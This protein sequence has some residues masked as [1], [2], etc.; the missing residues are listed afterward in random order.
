MPKRPIYRPDVARSTAQGRPQVL[1]ALSV[2]DGEEFFARAVESVLGQ[3]GVDLRLEIYDNGSTDGTLALADGYAAAD[4]RVT[5][6]RNPPGLNY[7]C[8]MNRAIAGCDAEFFCPWACDDVMSPD[9]LAVKAAGLREHPDAGFAWSPSLIVDEHDRIGDFY[10]AVAKLEP[11]SVAPTFFPFLVPIGQVVMSSVLARTEAMRAVGGFDARS[12]LVGDWLCWMKL[13]L[14]FGVVTI[15][16][17]LIHYR[18]HEG[19]GSFAAKRGGYAREEPA[20]LREAMRDPH[21]REEWRPGAAPWM[22]Q[23][24]AHIAHG[25]LENDILRFEQGFAA[26]GLAGQALP[27]LPKDEALVRYWMQL[28]DEAD[29]TRPHY[30]VRVV[31]E[32]TTDEPRVVR[33]VAEMRRLHE[34]GVT[35]SLRAVTGAADLLRVAKMLRRHAGGLDIE[36]TADPLTDLLAPGTVLLAELDAPEIAVAERHGIPAMIHNVPDCFD[37]PRDPERWETLEGPAAA[38]A[39]AA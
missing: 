28:I 19:C 34:A 12:V 18:Q 20:V 7:F 29:L 10:P 31:A 1:V 17:A 25:L 39:A 23:L 30:P 27:F 3:T 22:A 33:M 32:A 21:F 15:P 2:K 14:R 35:A 37:R 8:S 13:S 6:I 26:Y 24:I 36:L 38:R 16:H 9:N 4:P 11:Y 5:V